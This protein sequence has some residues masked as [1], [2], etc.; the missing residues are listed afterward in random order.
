M[1]QRSKQIIVLSLT[2]AAIAAGGSMP[3]GQQAT[4]IA[5]APVAAAATPLQ[6]VSV[7]ADVQSPTLLL[8]QGAAKAERGDYREAIQDLSRAI[9]LNPQLPEAYALRGGAYYNLGDKRQGGRDLA[10]A[11]ELYRRQGNFKNQQEMLNLKRR[12]DRQ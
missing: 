4:T 1:Q 12:L 5:A 6:Q 9:R 10:E 11:A 3:S 2:A 7:P 8:I